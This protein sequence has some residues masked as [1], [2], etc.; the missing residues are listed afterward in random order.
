MLTGGGGRLLWFFDSDFFWRLFG[1]RGQICRL[2][3]RIGWIHPFLSNTPCAIHHIIQ[4]RPKQTASAARHWINSS[5]Q[6]EATTFTFSSVFILLL[7]FHQSTSR[8]CIITSSGHTAGYVVL[9]DV[10]DMSCPV[11]VFFPLVNKDF[12]THV[13]P[14]VPRQPSWI[15]IGHV[16][17]SKGSQLLFM[18]SHFGLVLVTWLC[19]SWA[20]ILELY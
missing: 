13:A 1:A 9:Q 3:W 11:I 14:G 12:R 5:P 7:W 17:L 2:F 20:A 4:N 10:D 18:V 6:T 15:W 19:Y 8:H 16:T